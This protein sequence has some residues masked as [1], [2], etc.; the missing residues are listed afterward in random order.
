MPRAQN[1]HA[2]VNAAFLFELATNGTR[3]TVKSCRICYGGISPQFIHAEKT[4][5]LLTGLDDLYTNQNLQ[6][7]IQSLQT[8]LRPDFV[9]PDSAPEYRKRLAIALLY[10]FFLNTSSLQHRIRFDFKLGAT[11]IERPLSSGTQIFDTNKSLWPFTKPTLKIEGLIQCSGE[12]EYANDYFSK[13]SECDELW[14]A[15]VQTTEFNAKINKIDA[16]K[17]LVKFTYY[18]FIQT[19][20]KKFTDCESRYRKFL[21]FMRSIQQKTSRA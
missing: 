20:K 6:N 4:E 21:E 8:E 15:F 12:A 18:H 16:S 19:M 9:L 7:A 11:A 13:Y 1:A 5:Q 10:R 3:K 14:A 2:M 17:A